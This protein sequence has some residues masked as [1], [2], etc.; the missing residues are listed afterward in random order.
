MT[1]PVTDMD[2]LGAGPLDALLTQILNRRV[3]IEQRM[4]DAAAGK[5]PMP[6][7]AELRAWAI[8]LGTPTA[9]AAQVAQERC[10]ACNGNDAGAPCAFPEGGQPGCLRDKRVAQE[11][12]GVSASAYLA[13]VEADPRRAAALQ[14][15]RDRTPGVATDGA[16]CRLC[17]AVT[18]GRQCFEPAEPYGVPGAVKDSLIGA[19]GGPAL[20]PCKRCGGKG[21]YVE[22]GTTFVC[23]GCWGNGVQMDN[24]QPYEGKP[25]WKLHRCPDG[26]QCREAVPGGCS[27]GWCAHFGLKHEAL[28]SNIAGVKGGADV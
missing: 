8:E 13:K 19:A 1:A 4:F 2:A 27:A 23:G 9:T 26:E 21:K 12:G 3:T 20:P 17:L 10:P 16:V 25:G 15:A 7:A 22:H 5:R 28:H 11:G 14:R 18:G 6:D 24:N